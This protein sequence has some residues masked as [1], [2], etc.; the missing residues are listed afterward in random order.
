TR[1][2]QRDPAALAPA[3]LEQLL[4][5]WAAAVADELP[6]PD[7]FPDRAAVDD[8]LRTA[9]SARLSPAWI[10]YFEYFAAW[11]ARNR[12]DLRALQQAAERLAGLA[13]RFPELGNPPPRVL[14][15]A[16][17]HRALGDF[18]SA[19][20]EVEQLQAALP[21][22]QPGSARVRSNV[23]GLRSDIL[24]ETGRL[25]EAAQAM[26]KSL[27]LALADGDRATIENALLCDQAMALATGQFASSRDAILA[28]LAA[29]DPP[30]PVWRTTLLVFRGHAES[31]LA[32]SDPAGIA[33]A[34]ATLDEARAH[35]SGHLQ[36]R[37]DL[38]R[39][40]LALRAADIEGA[41]QASAD[42]SASLGAARLATPPARDACEF[43]GLS[44]RLLLLRGAGAAEL[45]AW[46]PR[47]QQALL[48]LGREWQQQPAQRGGIGFLHLGQRR[49]L[50]D[51]GIGLELAL[52]RAEGRADG[53]VRAL[54]L[55][56]DLQA[57][58]SLARARG[59]PA[60]SVA[61]VQRG[62]LADGR[63]AL[64]YLPARRAT[65]VFVVDRQAVTA[66]EL[67]G[68]LAAD[69]QLAT[70][71]S[72]LARAPTCKDDVRE[73]V[74]ASLARTGKLVRELLLPDDLPTRLAAYSG[75]TVVGADLLGGVPLEALPL[76]DG[77]LLG[78]V[79]PID[80]TASLPLVTALASA[81]TASAAP[82]GQHTDAAVLVLGCTQPSARVPEAPGL[83]GF[84]FPIAELRPGLADYARKAVVHSDAE[85]TRK[86]LL[87]ASFDDVDVLQIVAHEVHRRDGDRECG[88]LATDGV[89]WRSD[90]DARPVHGLVIVSSCGGGDGPGRIGEGEG[91]TSFVGAFLWNGARAVIASRNELQALDHLRLMA[92]CHA[93]L[94]R[95]DSPARALQQARSEMAMGSDLLARAQRALLQVSG[96]GQL[97]LL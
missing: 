78:E 57:H 93:H 20:A 19:L 39:F 65:W 49:D 36:V 13:R 1:Y 82:A 54:Q 6:P 27:D 9:V 32:G 42:C 44:T 69:E 31:G 37:A 59:A 40:D 83:A 21:D 66:R 38:K 45:R 76:E 15:L 23:L 3:A 33:R 85:V 88:L 56:L 58:T 63:A 18:G 30:D 97:P 67:P 80:N 12:G 16:D 35:G 29:I 87:G 64:V 52:A 96:A 7:G 92:R 46:Q 68:D 26:R 48:E 11:N 73:N 81:A 34:R 95:G 10:A 4:R 17:L 75:V 53:P 60:C 51:Q 94:A 77:R 61:F 8:A 91:F 2:R 89:V 86:A 55:L 72:R 14:L 24:R 47:Q 50:L 79:V 25:E 70:F 5:C 84:P 22:D 74:I 62:L 90:L 71:L 43:I 41:E 28:Q